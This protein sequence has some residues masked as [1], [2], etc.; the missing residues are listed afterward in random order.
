MAL[1]IY[2]N[3]I[4]KIVFLSL[5]SIISKDMNIFIFYLSMAKSIVL[6]VID[7]AHLK[8]S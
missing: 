7:I 2:V 6:I 4:E 8:I 5:M 1:H 3:I